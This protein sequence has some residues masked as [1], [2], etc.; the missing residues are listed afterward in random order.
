MQVIKYNYINFLY[1]MLYGIIYGLI[2]ILL[3]IYKINI[4][5]KLKLL[6]RFIIIR[7]S[8]YYPNHNEYVQIKYSVHFIWIITYT[9]NTIN[10]NKITIK[11]ST[12]LVG[13]KTCS[14]SVV[15]GSLLNPII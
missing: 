12:I 4:Y 14:L 2:I 7:R 8:N 15:N 6:Y 11:N 5:I 13:F 10:I 3:F 1:F 9:V